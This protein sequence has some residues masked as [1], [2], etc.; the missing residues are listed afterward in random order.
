M[1]DLVTANGSSLLKYFQ[2]RVDV[3]EDAAN[4]LDDTYLV[5][6]RKIRTLP[7]D[8]EASRMWLFGV[9]QNTLRNHRRGVWRR[10]ALQEALRA[11]IVRAAAVHSDQRDR[12]IDIRTAVAG[13]PDHQRELVLLVYGD[14]SSIEAAA[15]LLKISASTA[16][17]RHAS[18]KESLRSI[19][20]T[21][22]SP[23]PG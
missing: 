10:L 4:L 11:E 22:N 12:T 7:D 17:S 19:L 18:A 5:A 13:L 1:D 16:R 3:K 6:W 15:R 14:G 21:T 20:A 9:A 8:P 2:R 23:L